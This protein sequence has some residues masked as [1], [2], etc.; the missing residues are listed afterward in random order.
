MLENIDT[1]CR[2]SVELVSRF[3]FLSTLKFEVTRINFS[4]NR[5]LLMKTDFYC[6]TITILNKLFTHVIPEYYT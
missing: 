3:Y 4:K 2:Y 5:T 6:V 1:D